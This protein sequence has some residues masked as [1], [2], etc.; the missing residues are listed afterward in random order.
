[1]IGFAIT[2][3]VKE[4]SLKLPGPIVSTQWLSAHLNEP[5]LLIFE[6]RLTFPINKP[7]A[8]DVNNKKLQIQGARVFNWDDI[9]D[10]NST[11]P[12]MMPSEELFTRKM[13]TLGVCNNSI[14]V[15]YDSTG[16]YLSPRAWWM[17]KAMGHEQVAVLN[18]GLPVWIKE[19]LPCEESKN[20]HK[21]S[22]GNFIAK[23]STTHFCNAEQVENALHDNTY[24]IVDARSE[25]RFLGKEPEPR[26]G[27]RAGHIPNSHNI[28]FETVLE[29]G[30]YMK[31]VEELQKI[32]STKINH[33]QKLIFSCGSGGTACVLALAAE[34][35]GYSNMTVYDGSWSEWG[36]ESSLRPVA[37]I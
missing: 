1:M 35:A 14:I 12:H 18:G 16:I 21:F 20:N 9:S 4:I 6:T 32:F 31:S 25:N 33:Q 37:V 13:Q 29:D 7:I 28:P 2:D 17:L 5:N 30:M 36:L 15:I 11:L 19:N 24:A 8:E 26:N 10:P 22:E 27:L 23:Q 3:K 34:L